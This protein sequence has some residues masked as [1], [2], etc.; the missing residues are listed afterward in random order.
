MKKAII[1]ASAIML[2]GVFGSKTYGQKQLFGYYTNWSTY[3]KEFQPD[4]IS[5]LKLTA[6]LYAFFKPI[7]TS[8]TIES[9]DAWSDFG[10]GGGKDNIKKFINVMHSQKKPAIM[11]IGG[12]SYCY[13][14][15]LLGQCIQNNKELFASNIVNF[16]DN[17]VRA[18]TGLSFDGVDIDWEPYGNQWN[19]CSQQE[20]QNY[21]NFLDVLN[22]KIKTAYGSWYWLMIAMPGS[23][24]SIEK[25]GTTMVTYNGE[26]MSALTAISKIVDYMNV[27]AYDYNGPAFSSYT[28]LLSPVYSD[29]QSPTPA[30]V[31]EAV[32]LYKKYCPSENTWKVVLGFPAYGLAFQNIPNITPPSHDFAVGTYQSSDPSKDV[33]NGQWLNGNFDYKFIA[34]APFEYS[35]DIFADEENTQITGHAAWTSNLSYDGYD[36]AGNKKHFDSP[37]VWISWETPGT[38]KEKAK[39]VK[40]AGFGGMMVWTLDADIP[41]GQQGSL[42]DTARNALD[43]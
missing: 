7:P 38:L 24:A 29:P 30:G 43:N 25:L 40:D 41:S 22:K 8:F 23:K 35:Y 34:K 27:M 12:W 37:N 19:Q 5:V 3:A 36:D 33:P 21:V 13:P 16:I 11:S 4:N 10:D 20:L 26:S 14:V 2:L 1:V 39:L 17:V 6:A 18:K 42:I 15:D 31:Q 28:D 32:E 9:S